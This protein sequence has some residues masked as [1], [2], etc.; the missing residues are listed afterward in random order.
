MKYSIWLISAVIFSIVTPLLFLF[1]N[2]DKVTTQPALSSTTGSLR[3]IPGQRGSSPY[4]EVLSAQGPYKFVCP[5]NVQTFPCDEP[6]DAFRITANKQGTVIYH[7]Y[8]QAPI[9]AGRG[10]VDTLK[11]GTL[12]FKF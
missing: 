8:D 3:F 7:K 5:R 9:D 1:N 11:I 12:V 4:L 6:Q 10:V 2:T